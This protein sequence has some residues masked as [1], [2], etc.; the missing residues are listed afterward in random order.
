MPDKLKRDIRL[1]ILACIL[2]IVATLAINAEAAE[3]SGE[4]WQTPF[5]WYIGADCP[6][7]VQPAVEEALEKY[8]PVEHHFVRIWTIG[9]SQ[10]SSSVIYCG[11]SDEQETQLQKPLPYWLDMDDQATAAGRARWYFFKTQQK[12]VECDVW[13]SSLFMNED[14]VDRYV[15]H[16][17][18]GHCMGLQHSNYTDA[19][20]Y[21]APSVNHLHIDD[22]AGLTQL[23]KTCRAMPFVDA[24]GNMYLPRLDVEDLLD[25]LVKAGASQDYSEYRGKEL[26]AYLPALGEWP[27]DV[28]AIQESACAE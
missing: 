16:E 9:V 26:Q 7:Y 2:G 27:L 5:V 28:Y 11:Y 19:V 6:A 20:M 23:Y 10:D 22:M 1:A 14:N 24:A 18:L 12:I 4:H 21:Y 15:L 17:V 13:L 3:Y 25:G 8:S